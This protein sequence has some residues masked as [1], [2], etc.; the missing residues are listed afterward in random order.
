[1]T[2]LMDPD[3]YPDDPRPCDGCD[4]PTDARRWMATTGE[5]LCWKC[6]TDP[7]GKIAAFLSW[8]DAEIEAARQ[9]QRDADYPGHMADTLETLERV[10]A[11]LVG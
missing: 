1:M 2:Q 6:T 8:L 5:S 9:L 3:I 11:R 4:S 10:K 7:T